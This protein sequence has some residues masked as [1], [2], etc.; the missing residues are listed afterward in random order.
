MGSCPRCG[1]ILGNADSD[2]LACPSCHGVFVF[3][4]S[5]EAY[6]SN[7]GALGE[8]TS[9][10]QSAKPKVEGGVE[11]GAYE[12]EFR[13]LV[14]PVCGRTMNRENMRRSGV[15]VDTCLFHGTWFDADEAWRVAACVPSDRKDR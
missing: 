8:A 1:A 4:A 9:Y 12:P 15:I 10:R 13:Y 3:R 6:L 2:G 7:A 14:C 5:L 11:R